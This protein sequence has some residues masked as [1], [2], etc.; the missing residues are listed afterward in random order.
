MPESAAN[1]AWLKLLSTPGLGPVGARRLLSQYGSA[2]A[3]LAQAPHTAAT[4]GLSDIQL[5]YWRE[6]NSAALRRAKLWLE[7]DNNQLLLESDTRYPAALRDLRDAPLGLFASG[8]LDLLQGLHLAIVGSRNPSPAGARHARLF[9]KD[10][11]GRG[12]TIVSGLASGIDAQSH[13]GALEADG[14]TVAI[15]GTG[16]DIVYPASNRQLAEAIARKGLL[17]SEFAPGIK[18]KRDHFPRRNRL[19]AAL[20]RGTL[21]VEA[22][23]RS[24]SLITARLAAEL[25]REVMAMPGAVDNPLA[26]GCH[27]L[28]RQGAKL[29]ESSQDILEELGPIMDN[30]ARSYPQTESTTQNVD[31]P[32]QD[33][34]Y[35]ELLQFLD[36]T[37]RSIDELHGLTGRP[38]NELSS[39]LLILELQG[40][41]AATTNGRY[42]KFPT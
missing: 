12:L 33:Q 8:D 37:P 28:I 25:G 15:T 13:H 32:E 9:A 1:D 27:S 30:I 2:D 14:M 22:A 21:V 23:L 5:A 26:R 29:V 19:I 10:L 20:S 31:T 24:G 7:Q 18:A 17:I 41:I 4:L 3:V 11:A 42:Q 40:S 35:H 16:L 39:M 6:D 34:S 38:V 36:A